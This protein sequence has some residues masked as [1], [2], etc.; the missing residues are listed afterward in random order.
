MAKRNAVETARARYEAL[1]YEVKS[2]RLENVLAKY[3]AV[4]SSTSSKKRRQPV[5]ETQDDHQLLT[6]AGRLRSVGLARDLQR[7]FVDAAAHLRQFRNAAVGDGPKLA[8][9]TDDEDLNADIDHWFNNIYAHNCSAR[10][11]LTLRML[12]GLVLQ[13][14]KREGDVVIAFDDFLNDDGRLWFWES[15]Q[16]CNM[17][18]A[19]FK[20]NTQFPVDQDYSQDEGVIYDVNGREVGYIVSWKRGQMEV[21][22]ED[23]TILPVGVAVMI[24][25]PW[26]LNQRRGVSEMLN[27]GAMYQD[28]YEILS[29]ELQSAKVAAGLAG[30]VKR[31]EGAEMFLLDQGTDPESIIDNTASSVVTTPVIPKNY[32]NLEALTGGYME[33]I[34]PEDEVNILNWDRPNINLKDFL[35]R[36]TT[37]AGASLGL[38]KTYATLT[39]AGSFTA[40]RGD[41]LLTWSQFGWD[42]KTL[43]QLALDWIATKAI[44]WAIRKGLLSNIPADFAQ[45]LFWQWPKMPSTDPLK[46]QKSTSESLANLTTD[47][48]AELG[49]NWKKKLE[50]AAEQRAMLEEVGLIYP[51]HP[52]QDPENGVSNQE[53]QGENEEEFNDGNSNLR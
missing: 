30:V 52:W 44:G 6:S 21:S 49:P 22:A 26:R 50:R 29:K 10:D 46:T 35:D 3:D 8:I 40:F 25:D 38:A 1:S 33:Y 2:R 23:A 12:V 39:P 27:P 34:D 15:D 42:Q 5:I 32:D 31:Q 18:E 51:R 14:V 36:V 17:R 7:N 13:S 43:E 48:A 19:D 20:K 11:R 47:Y 4:D 41:M 37:S 53:E 16:I 45:R 9:Q 24:R 28:S